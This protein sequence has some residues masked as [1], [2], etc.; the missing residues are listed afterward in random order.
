MEDYRKYIIKWANNNKGYGYIKKISTKNKC[1]INTL[2]QYDAK[3]YRSKKSAFDDISKLLWDYKCIDDPTLFTII[4]DFENEAF[5]LLYDPETDT[6][7]VFD[8]TAYKD[9]NDYFYIDDYID[10]ILTF[11]YPD[12]YKII[13]EKHTG[14]DELEN[15]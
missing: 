5:E 15:K 6:Q 9:G 14:L 8:G 11:K 2:D 3:I 13:R 1:F 4:D 7:R 10:R 12:Y